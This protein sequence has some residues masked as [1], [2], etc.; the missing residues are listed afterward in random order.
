M[1]RP[2]RE[3]A[4]SAGSA[5]G[6]GRRCHGSQR[7][8]SVGRSQALVSTL[9]SSPRRLRRGRRD[10]L[11]GHVRFRQREPRD[12][13]IVR[14]LR[15]EFRTLEQTLERGSEERFVIDRPAG[16]TAVLEYDRPPAFLGSLLV[17]ER[18]RVAR[19]KPR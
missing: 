17:L 8:W 12:D 5:S 6:F 9:R 15:A 18:A 3:R 16:A 1:R 13:L 2:T 4:R 19:G 14:F 10:G 11:L 7:R